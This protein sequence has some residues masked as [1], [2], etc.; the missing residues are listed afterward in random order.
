VRLLPVS[1]C[2]A[3]EMLSELRGK[4][5]FDGF[6]GAP[7]IDLNRL[8]RAIAAI[9]NAALALGPRLV[10]LEVNPLLAFGDQVEALDGLAVWEKP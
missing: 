4:A 3:L 6:R 5:L 1:E 10:A 9:G 8:A 7:P 2:E